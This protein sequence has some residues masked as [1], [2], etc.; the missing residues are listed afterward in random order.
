VVAEVRRGGE[1]ERSNIFVHMMCTF[2][3]YDLSVISI[4]YSVDVISARLLYNDI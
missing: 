1:V 2:Q 3:L 4:G